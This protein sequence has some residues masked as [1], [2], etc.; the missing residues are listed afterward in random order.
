MIEPMS[1]WQRVLA[2]GFALAGLA[3]GQLTE[4]P[5]TW[6][7]GDGQV[8]ADAR[9]GDLMAVAQAGSI[10]L[11]A[12][13]AAGTPR[14]EAAGLTAAFPK[15]L[16]AQNLNLAWRVA[17]RLLAVAEGLTPGEWLEVATAYD[18][19]LDRAVLTPGSRL[20]ARL[21][22]WFV[23]G[24]PLKQE[25]AVRFSVLD[26]GGKEIN[27]STEALPQVMAAHEQAIATQALAPGRY[28]LRF[29][30]RQGE[31]A[32]LSCERLFLVDANLRGRLAAL[33]S[34]LRRAQ[35]RGAAGGRLDAA[36]AGAEHAAATM[37]LWLDGG[38]L[39]MT[40]WRHPFVESI[41]AKRLPAIAGPMP[42]E[43][44]WKQ[45]ERIAEALAQ[46]RDPFDGAA[47]EHRLAQR[48]AGGGLTPYRLFVPAG[49]AAASRPLV[50]LRHSFL[51]GEGSWG[52]VLSGGT[53]ADLAAKHGALVLCP[54]NP[55]AFI[56]PT[57]A[58]GKE[59]DN[60]VAEVVKS[61]DADPRRVYLAGHGTA[62]AEALYY[63][64]GRPP[65]FAGAAAVAGA[66][67]RLF[68]MRPGAEV[69]VLFV[70]SADDEIAPAQELR[71]WAA[72]V[73]TRLKRGRQLT[74][75]KLSHAEVMR[76]ALPK[77][78]EFFL[79]SPAAPE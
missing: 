62:A 1:V 61:F 59:L 10:A 5:E 35:L 73:E 47:V 68:D 74:L 30:L 27:S 56:D 63:A 38:P 66:P 51:A 44:G 53:L 57:E 19:E 29:E 20:H 24:Y 4:K 36:L 72:Y 32:L 52:G 15:L 18:L 42:D 45:A 46:G 8:A 17:T 48:T 16:Q 39:G 12:A 37:Q 13:A 71:K 28:R 3:W 79:T 2:A 14:R 69:P 78:F 60:L 65:R 54:W 23:L 58:A 7:Q 77:L 64:L 50:V 6:L 34:N 75:E 21:A 70:Y 25:Y 31:R 9:P 40:G 41:A 11:R 33:R 49:A 67:P 76:E 55:L 22:P 43:D 26:A